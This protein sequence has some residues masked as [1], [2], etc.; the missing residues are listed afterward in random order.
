[1]EKEKA[2]KLLW[3]VEWIRFVILAL[4]LTFLFAGLGNS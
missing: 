2:E 3:I 4:L 1:M